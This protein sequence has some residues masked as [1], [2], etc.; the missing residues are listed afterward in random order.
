MRNSILG[1]FMGLLAAAL[2]IVAMHWF[3][4]QHFLST[5]KGNPMLG[6][7]G[8]V[9]T[10]RDFMEL[11]ATLGVKIG[12]IHLGYSA[13]WID[14]LTEF[15]VVA[16]IAFFGCRAAALHP[17]CRRCNNWKQPRVLGNLADREEVVEA[18][19]DGDLTKL[20]QRMAPV[21]GTGFIL[22]AFV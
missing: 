8:Q 7:L 16:L 21:P 10:F 9:M 4:Y 12:D 11:S 14:W 5:A 15:V 1:G 13:T 2:A 20:A 19:Q 3:D 18:I 17:F 6:I 22:N